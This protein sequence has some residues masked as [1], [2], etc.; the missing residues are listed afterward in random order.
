MGTEPANTSDRE[1]QVNEAIAAFLEAAETGEELDRDRYINDHPDIAADLRAFFDDREQFHRLAE[2]LGAAVGPRSSGV[3]NKSTQAEVVAGEKTIPAIPSAT[4]ADE[5]S[6]QFGAYEL[7]EEIARGGMGVVYKAR[8]QSL[9]RTVAIKMILSARLASAADVQRFR[10]EAETVAQ[11][12]HPGIVPIYEVGEREGQHF[13]SMKLI[14]GGSLAQ[15]RARWLD[16][17]P[18]VAKLVARVARTIHFAHQRGLLHRD[19]KPANIL[20]DTAGNTYVTDFGLAKLMQNDAGLTP[21]GGVVGTPRYMAPEQA[22]GK[23]TPTVA[24]DVYGLG[25]ILYEL[26]TGRPPFTGDSPL[27]TMIKVLEQEPEHPR[28]INARVPRDLEAIC[29][30]CLE[31]DPARRYGSAEALADDLERFVAG[32]AILARPTGPIDRAWRWCRRKPV[33]AGLS[34]ALVL[35]FFGA[36]IV[37]TALWQHAVANFE[38]KERQRAEAERLQS[39]AEENAREARKQQGKAEDGFRRA[40]DLVKRFC[41]EMSEKHLAGVPGLQPLRQKLL[42]GAVESYRAFV[43]ERPDDPV[44]QAELGA[45]LAWSA[46]VVALTGSQAKAAAMYEEAAALFRTVLAEHPDK[47]NI[48]NL[49]ADLGR[50]YNRLGILR[51]HL[52]RPAE[53]SYRQARTLFEELTHQFPD[54]LAYQTD[55][56]A[57]LTNLGGLYHGRGQSDDALRT[58]AQDLAIYER[59]AAQHPQEHK[60]QHSLSI[61]HR[62]IAAVQTARGQHGEA[63]SSREKARMIL[64]KL[65]QDHPQVP[66]YQQSLARSYRSLGADQRAAGKLADA[67]A[68]LLL[69]QERLEKLVKDN[70]S[71]LGYQHDLAAVHREAGHVHLANKQLAKA[72][73]SYQEARTLGEKLVGVDP[74][75]FDYQNDLAKSWSDMASVLARNSQHKDAA[76]CYQQASDIRTKLLETHANSRELRNQLVNSLVSLGQTRWG[77]G[78]REEGAKIV[79]GAI[80]QLR[81]AAKDPNELARHRSTLGFAYRALAEMEAKSGRLAEGVDAYIAYRAL[82]PNDAAK[83]YETAREL[84]L[85]ASWVGK[86]KPELSSDEKTQRDRYAQLAVAT[87]RDAVRCGFKDRKRL[88]EDNYLSSIRERQDFQALLAELL[89]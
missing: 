26:L 7:L 42:D 25:T 3:G 6:R 37:V 19:L 48:I 79:R 53:D 63:A 68:S 61:T 8:Q 47:V 15:H 55:L 44:L 56:A 88:E 32:E 16:D 84:A 38:E 33:V 69:A 34:A 60:L 80:S 81:E 24:I 67:Q 83:Q 41:T 89:K 50:V 58:Y 75:V 71:V 9:G 1:E 17:P 12:D 45:T 28:V 14:E 23:T 5:P 27:D 46:G 59:L 29:L 87:L 11:L 54:N 73:D 66:E 72:L 77:M 18:A 21:S 62:N 40:H 36:F 31:K 13:F 52:G 43:R 65:A 76:T 86:D 70:P 10:S 51:E 35:L 82:W 30:K 74:G 49:K 20:L 2:P 4:A 22:V 78:Q 39:T 85:I 57:I 64:E